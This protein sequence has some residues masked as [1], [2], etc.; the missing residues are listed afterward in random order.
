MLSLRLQGNGSVPNTPTTNQLATPG[1]R[2][3]SDSGKDAKQSQQ[4]FLEFRKKCAWRSE[5]ETKICANF[6]KKAACVLASLLMKA[7]K[8]NKNPRWIL[9]ED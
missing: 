6:H 9:S 2:C 1:Q 3:F 8:N 4:I 5:H 7:C